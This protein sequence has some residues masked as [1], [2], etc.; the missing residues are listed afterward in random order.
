MRDDRGPGLHTVSTA[1]QQ[2][3]QNRKG[4]RWPRGLLRRLR[5]PSWSWGRIV[6]QFSNSRNVMLRDRLYATPFRWLGS[7]N[8]KRPG[9]L[10]ARNTR[11]LDPFT[12]FVR[13]HFH[14]PRGNPPRY[15]RR[16]DAANHHRD[17]SGLLSTV[18]SSRQTQSAAFMS[19]RLRV[20]AHA[21]RRALRRRAAGRAP[22]ARP[23]RSPMPRHGRQSLDGR[24]D[25]RLKGSQSPFDGSFGAR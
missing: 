17:C 11:S 12:Q 24:P 22:T 23:C 4:G 16:A 19:P 25:R 21:G 6:C 8:A 18:L 3:P 14:L 10:T 20:S 13:L 9:Y 15:P 1:F 2:S 7:L 5:L